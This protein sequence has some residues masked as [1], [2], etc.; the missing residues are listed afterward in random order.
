MATASSLIENGWQSKLNVGDPVYIEQDG[1]PIRTV[2]SGFLTFDRDYESPILAITGGCPKKYDKVFL[3]MTMHDDAYLGSVISCKNGAVL[4]ELC[5]KSRETV[6]N[7]LRS[8]HGEV[9][10]PISWQGSMNTLKD[11][12]ALC[13]TGHN[14]LPLQIVIIGIDNDLKQPFFFETKPGEAQIGSLVTNTQG[15]AEGG[16]NLLA[17]GPVHCHLKV[18]G[19]QAALVARIYKAIEDLQDEDSRFRGKTAFYLA[20]ILQPESDSDPASKAL[21]TVV[22]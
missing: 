17:Y 14:Q 11:K 4:I 6:S 15:G 9:C 21:K 18:E 22:Y 16:R 10:I 8:E 2:L 1:L 5:E 20:P 12:P 13:H 3:D 19:R 7:L